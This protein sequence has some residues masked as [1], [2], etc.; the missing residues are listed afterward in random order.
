MSRSFSRPVWLAIAALV[1][2]VAAGGVAVLAQ[3]PHVLFIQQDKLLNVD[4]TPPTTD[5]PLGGAWG[6]EVGTATGGLTGASV[7]N[8]KLTFTS[9]P[10][11]RPV[12]FNFDARSG[13]TDVDGD[14]IIFKCQGTGVFQVSLLD[15]TVGGN[16][17]NP[18]FQ[19]FGNGSDGPLTGACEVVATSGKFVGAFPIGQTYPV[20]LAISNPAA[21]PTP[22]GTVGS[23]YLEVLDAKK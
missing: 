16:P 12:T 22:A 7:L 8:F 1:L 9:N 15:P 19:V 10:F 17:G 14:Q 5:Q 20:R 6:A 4:L 3:K 11:V 21:P 13:I 18:P 2:S 23:V